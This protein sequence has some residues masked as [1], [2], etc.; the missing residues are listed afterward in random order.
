MSLATVVGVLALAHGAEQRSEPA[1]RVAVKDGRLSAHAENLPLDRL[2]DEISRRGNVAIIKAGGR[3]RPVS[4]QLQDVP[5]DEGLRQILR[6][7]D[8]FFFYGVGAS[9]PATL[10][11]VWVYPKGKGRELQPVPPEAWASTAELDG[12]VA[13]PDPAVRARAIEALVERRGNQASDAVS[14]ALRDHD[15]QVRVR[16]LYQA[17][18]AGVQLPRD[19]LAAF[20]AGD[21]S[22]DVRFLALEALAADPEARMFAEAAL[23]DSSPH[24]RGKARE[25]LRALDIATR[26]SK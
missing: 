3:G 7:Q 13:D 24:V 9:G 4:V 16:A 10:K 5:L 19:E 18:H 14:E 17:I 23:N 2:L 8:T 21:P 15:D 6:N 1:P 25:L 20:A 22:P 26:K 11:V 12:R